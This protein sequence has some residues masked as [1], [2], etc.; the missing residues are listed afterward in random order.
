MVRN[1]MFAS[2]EELDLVFVVKGRNSVAGK[3]SGGLPGIN[4][5][6]VDMYHAKESISWREEASGVTRICQSYTVRHMGNLYLADVEEEASG[7]MTGTR[8]CS[9]HLGCQRE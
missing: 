5:I 3:G 8:T 1:F 6:A 7:D 9:V 4:R 2:E